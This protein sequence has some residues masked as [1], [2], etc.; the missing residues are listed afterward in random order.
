MA[1]PNAAGV[2]FLG[3][4]NANGT[5]FYQEDDKHSTT[6][7]TAGFTAGTGTAAND[8]S[9]FTGNVGS[10]AYTIGDLVAALKGA[11]ILKS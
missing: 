6:G 4:S 3:D 11:G 7:V 8:D 9:T 10:K 2:Q 5:S 1:N